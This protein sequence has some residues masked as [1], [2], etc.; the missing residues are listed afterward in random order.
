MARR[1]TEERGGHHHD[2][3]HARDHHQPLHV[4]FLDDELQRQ[5]QEREMRDEVLRHR[6]R[7]IEQAASADAHSQ[8]GERVVGEEGP[9]DEDRAD[10][11]QHVDLADA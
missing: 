11:E 9:D 10:R 1:V 5:D 3:T 4:A 8:G 2:E 7:L 6:P